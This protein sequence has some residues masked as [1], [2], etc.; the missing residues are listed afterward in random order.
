MVEVDAT[1]WALCGNCVDTVDTVRTLWI[2]GGREVV[3]VDRGG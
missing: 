1:V 2:V 3:V